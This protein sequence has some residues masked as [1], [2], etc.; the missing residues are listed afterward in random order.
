MP[1]ASLGRRLAPRALARE[2]RHLPDRLLHPLRRRRALARVR[3]NAPASVLV[4]CHG[5]ICRS[6]YAAAV[7]RR[8]VD[9]KGGGR[10]RVDSA[11]FIGPGRPPPSSARSVARAH[12]IDLEAHVSKVVTPSLVATAELIIVMDPRQRR[13]I[14]DRF[15]PP[16]GSV[17]LLGD[18]DPAP[19]R[20]RT[21]LD[22]INRSEDVFRAVYSR[23]DRCMSTLLENL[24][25][26]GAG[27][28]KAT[29]GGGDTEAGS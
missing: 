26:D 29:T 28:A 18:L 23:V 20:R 12:G 24:A 16:A 11:G 1:E 9:E 2:L 10:V 8:D 6:P 3:Q 14:E 19:I 22:P 15:E 7:L 4:V 21:V 27:A 25:P 17:L 13:A 5:N